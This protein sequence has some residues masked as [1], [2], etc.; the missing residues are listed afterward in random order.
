MLTYLASPYSHP[1]RAVREF[2]FR[3][4]CRVA[5]ALMQRG[6]AIF[7]PIAHSHPI[8]QFFDGVESLGF[9]M[10][11]DVAVLRHCSKLKVLTLDGW[12]QSK[13]VAA[14]TAMAKSLL[15]PVEYVDP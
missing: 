7:S 6:E 15:I 11:Q 12:V 10:R 14:E 8:E 1:D 13:G 3:E 9:W 4:A 2:R 5:A